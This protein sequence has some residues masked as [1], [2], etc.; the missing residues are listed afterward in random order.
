MII[1]IM[2]LIYVQQYLVIH[3]EE[4]TTETVEE[5]VEKAEETEEETKEETEKETE[6][7]VEK[8]KIV[9]KY[10]FY[11]PEV[12]GKSGYYIKK[13]RVIIH[14][15]SEVGVT[16]YC[17]KRE[18]GECEEGILKEKE[19]KV[20][21][22]ENAFSEGEN[23]LYI[24]MEDENGEKIEKFAMKK[25]ILIDT[26]EPEIQ[27]SAPKGF[28]TWYQQSVTVSVKGEDSESGVV[29]L[30]CKAGE[31][32]VGSIEK[33]QG[34]FLITQPSVMQKGINITVTA[35]DKAGNKSEKT[36]TVYIDREV[37]KAVISGANNYM[38]T[39]KTTVITGILEEE[40]ALKEYS[41]QIIREDTKGKRK[42]LDISEWKTEGTRKTVHCEL[43]KDGVYYI[44]IN[45]KDL[46]GHE[47][48]Q[49][50][51]IIIDKTN[52]VIR[53]IDRLDQRYLKK[54]QWNYQPRQI[55][56]DFTTYTY[57]LRIDGQIYHAGKLI[58]AEGRH[59]M[60]VK[61]VD[62]A[63]N[64]AFAQAEF[65]IDHTAPEIIIKNVKDGREYEETRTVEVE[66]GKE[67]DAISQIQ[68]NGE[69]QKIIPEQRSYQYELQTCQDYEIIVRAVDRAGNESKKT[70]Y[71][72]IIPKKILINKITE[73]VKKYLSKERQSKEQ[74][75]NKLNNRQSG[76]G[77]P[78]PFTVAS[79]SAVGMI[80]I[81][82]GNILRKK[83]KK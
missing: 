81:L 17:L 41:L 16:K 11:I 10:E 22:E 80:S 75:E 12:N 72:R 71:F 3:A 13:P 48:M 65:I 2:C 27:M 35:E 55:I 58:S 36:K 46:S 43:K 45:G 37:P 83:R 40:N 39:A 32:F 24:W 73:P 74:S 6:G 76:T 68:I 66:L 8:E 26:K 4:R 53:Y 33:N 18:D 59:K 42:K 63:G 20:V 78:L 56:Q 25:E 54:F 21:I 15:I 82:G 61:A 60:I 79:L 34:E 49:R 14:H 64:Q 30:S 5:I 23:Q 38:I 44:K 28:D 9:E 29:N 51:Q 57:D 62:A 70:V 52:P 7:E 19:E 31:N 47:T 1:I 69:N 77:I 50:M 67:S